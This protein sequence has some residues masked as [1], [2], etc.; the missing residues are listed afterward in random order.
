MADTIEIVVR[1]VDEFTDNLGTFGNIITGIQSAISLAA[2]AFEAASDFVG[3]FVESA[4]EG[5]QAI[6]RLEGVLQATGGAAG[7]TSE[8]LQSLAGALQEVTR[9]SDETILNGTALMLTFRNIGDET[10][11]RAIPAM[12]DM[13]EIFGSV[14][15][16][17][18]QLGKAL[19]DPVNMLGALTRAGVTFTEEQKE[20]IK[21]FVEMGDIASAQAIILAEVEAQVG[22]LAETMGGTFAGQV[23]I[24]KN[25]LD[26]MKEVIGNALLPF[27]TDLLGKFTEFLDSPAVAGFMEGV[28]ENINRL[29]DALQNG[30]DIS[31]L[32]S[33]MFTGIDWEQISQ[34]FADGMNAIDWGAISQNVG[35]L[36]SVITDILTEVDWSAVAGAVW[37]SFIQAFMVVIDNGANMLLEVLADAFGDPDVATF[38][39]GVQEGAAEL[40]QIFLTAIFPPN[41]GFILADELQEIAGDVIDGL[42]EGWSNALSSVGLGDM[43]NWWYERIVE[44]LKEILGISSPSTVFREIG[45]NIVLGLIGGIV[46]MS[47]AISVIAMSIGLSIINGIMNG[48]SALWNALVGIVESIMDLFTPILEAL[49]IITSTSEGGLGSDTGDSGTGEGDEEGGTVT[50]IYNFYGPTYVYGVGPEGEYDCSA[51]PVI[52]S[53]SNQLVTSGLGA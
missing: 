30:E 18:M 50:N 1:A 17:A 49:G 40:G 32:L 52:T 22:G 37:E 38:Q 26:E 43:A 4:S 33:N 16:A 3:Q 10:M 21:A 44:P 11:L 34:D 51:D 36:S 47:N 53:T 20:M 7:L 35:N 39:A 15:S 8:D 12:L 25:K 42:W 9:F 13:A 5:E 24:A 23:E 28:I 48:I 14:D 31:E 41:L 46:A 27:L 29:L 2:D 6:A 45:I 19:N